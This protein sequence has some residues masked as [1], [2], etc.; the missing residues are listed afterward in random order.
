MR[1]KRKHKVKR[2]R[3]KAPAKPAKRAEERRAEPKDAQLVNRVPAHVLE[4]LG[5]HLSTQ[6]LQQAVK[7]STQFSEAFGPTLEVRKED[8]A[9]EFKSLV[10]LM[11]KLMRYDGVD[12]GEKVAAHLSQDHVVETYGP[13]LTVSFHKFKVEV[14]YADS[15]HGEISYNYGMLC[16]CDRAVDSKKMNV[17]VVSWLPANLVDSMRYHMKSSLPK[18]FR[19]SIRQF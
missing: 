10:A 11:A 17:S 5:K 3:A 18:T 2:K 14:W 13:S 16:S 4:L 19:V 8:E 1:I 9:K 12:D 15:V 7:V 6:N